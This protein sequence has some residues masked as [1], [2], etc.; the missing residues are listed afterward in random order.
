MVPIGFLLLAAPLVPAPAE[1]RTDTAIT[2]LAPPASD[3]SKMAV[4]AGMRARME[5]EEIQFVVSQA[6]FAPHLARLVTSVT[7]RPR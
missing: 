2:L 3:E 6:V 1:L 5:L 4:W 7:P